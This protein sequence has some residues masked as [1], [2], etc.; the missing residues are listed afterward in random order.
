[1]VAGAVLL[2]RMVRPVADIEQQLFQVATSPSLESCELARS[3]ERRRRG[4]RLESRGPATSSRA[5]TTESLQQRIR[6]SLDHGRQGRLDAVLNSIPDGVAT[7][8]AAGRLT[9]TNL[10]MS[11]ILGLKDVVGGGDGASEAENAP[12]HDR[13]VDRSAGTCRS[14]IRCLSAENRDRPV[15][16]ELTR[17]ENGQRR[18]VRVARHPICIVGGGKHECARVDRSAT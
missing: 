17:E 7:T 4:H 18:V 11:V 14:R 8:D 1:M 6:Q 10:P 5:V 9:Y 16:T 3:S 12:R 13:P 2:N 15:V